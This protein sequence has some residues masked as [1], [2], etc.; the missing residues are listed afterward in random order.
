MREQV[1]VNCWVLIVTLMPSGAAGIKQKAHPG[2]CSFGGWEVSPLTL[3]TW[4]QDCNHCFCPSSVLFWREMETHFQ[5]LLSTC[6]VK[7][8]AAIFFIYFLIEG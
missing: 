6:Y 5:E 4:K 8:G 3:I 1:A 2:C 7:S